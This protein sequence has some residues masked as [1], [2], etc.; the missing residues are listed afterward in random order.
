MDPYLNIKPS[1]SP[2]FLSYNDTRHSLDFWNDP[3]TPMLL[4]IL[5]FILLFIVV[6]CYCIKEKYCPNTCWV[7]TY[8][9]ELANRTIIRDNIPLTPIRVQPTIEQLTRQVDVLT[10]ILL[11]LAENELEKNNDETKTETSDTIDCIE[12]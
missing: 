11:E 9:T 1:A 7:S 4:V 6:I 10:T 12:V 3:T 5:L 2:T 8:P